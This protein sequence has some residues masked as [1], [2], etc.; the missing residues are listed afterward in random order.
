MEQYLQK[1]LQSFQ[2]STKK[3]SKEILIDWNKTEVTYP[4]LEQNKTIVQLFE[5]QVERTPDN[6]AV[7]YENTQLTYQELNERANRL[8]H[9]LKA[10][11]VKPDVLVAI[12]VDRSLD[13]M[14]GLLG[15]LKAGGAYVPL[16]PDYPEERLKYML[17]DTGVEILLTQQEVIESQVLPSRY[18]AFNDK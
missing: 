13:M 11:G 14:I 9:Y 4:E 8:A 7:V 10:L 17:E 2:F 15:I 5:E 6:I 18:T 16:D 3:R 1:L 12:M